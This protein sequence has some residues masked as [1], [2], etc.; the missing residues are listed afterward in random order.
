MGKPFIRFGNK[1]VVTPDPGKRRLSL[2]DDQR[3]RFTRSEMC[4]VRGLIS[5]ISYVRHGEHDL[6]ARLKDGRIRRGWWKYRS[7]VGALQAIVQE[8]LETAPESQTR[9]AMNTAIDMAVHIV[10]KTTPIGQNVVMDMQTAKD[11]T[12]CA[13]EM[14]K[15][16]T[17]DGESC[18]KCKLYKV[19]EATTP[20]E[21]Y[22]NGM[23][24]PYNMTT[25]EE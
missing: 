13:Q 11:L 24:C 10:P 21:D 20:L 4:A 9:Q 25:W 12:D 8:I 14:C 6:E 7:T 5:L 18:R 22:G 19:M 2:S 15:L 1:L 16:C 3:T 23:L 17:E